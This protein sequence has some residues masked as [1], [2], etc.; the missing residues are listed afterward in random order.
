M[1]PLTTIMMHFCHLFLKQI[2]LFKQN[3]VKSTSFSYF[4]A[5]IGA[6]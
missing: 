6:L 1:S 4:Q 3:K 2:L 5:S